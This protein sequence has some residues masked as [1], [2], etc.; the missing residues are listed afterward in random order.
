[1]FSSA[2]SRRILIQ[3]IEKW[4]LDTLR[5]QTNWDFGGLR[6]ISAADDFAC[7]AVAGVLRDMLQHFE[8]IEQV[9][10]SFDPCLPL[11][12]LH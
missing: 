7:C 5:M 11:G 12:N 2:F 9:R 3:W 4:R 1:M 8:F 10:S 6:M